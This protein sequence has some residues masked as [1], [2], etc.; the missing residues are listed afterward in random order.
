MDYLSTREIG[1]DVAHRVPTHGSKCQ[2]L[3]G[4]RYKIEAV[5]QGSLASSGEQTGMTLDF[6]FIKEGM[7]TLIDAYFDHATTLHVSDPLAALLLNG[8]DYHPVDD[9]VDDPKGTILLMEDSGEFS[10]LPTKLC[11]LTVIPTAENLAA[12]WYYRLR[13]FVT[14]RSDGRAVLSQVIVWETPN[15]KSAYPAPVTA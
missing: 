5:I 11:L 13:N 3:H 15:C 10:G 12:L 4:H 9:I 6:G 14:C 7:M 2:R 1:I 8:G